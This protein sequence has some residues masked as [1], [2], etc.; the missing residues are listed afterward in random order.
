M[1][2]ESK[3]RCLVCREMAVLGDGLCNDCWDKRIDRSR[4]GRMGEIV[5]EEAVP[6]NK[7]VYYVMRNSELVKATRQQFMFAISNVRYYES[8]YH[9]RRRKKK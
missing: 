3:G 2:A 1:V 5:L 4:V 6:Q 9:G 7:T 8:K